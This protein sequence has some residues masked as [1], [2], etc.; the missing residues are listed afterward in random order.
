MEP[1]DFLLWLS[2]AAGSS[3]ALSFLLERIPAFHELKPEHRSLITLGGSLGI[4]LAAWAILTYVPADVLAQITPVFQLVA[5]VVGSWIATQL[6]HTAD[7]A[8]IEKA[9]A[10]AQAEAHED[11][12][13]DG[14][15]RVRLDDLADAVTLR[16]E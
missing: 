3:A 12:T 14:L 2:S 9:Q 5:A 4:A 11:A 16:K 10:E 15:T 8:R 6:A 13:S 7:P 1:R